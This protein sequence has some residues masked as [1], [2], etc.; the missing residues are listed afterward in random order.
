MAEYLPSS[1]PNLERIRRRPVFL[2]FYDP[3]PDKR[4]KYL[5]EI[6][7]CQ[8]KTQ[9]IISKVLIASKSGLPS[10]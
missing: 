7:F 6:I 1:V 8:K 9:K 4:D 3:N 5:Y 10:R 2:S